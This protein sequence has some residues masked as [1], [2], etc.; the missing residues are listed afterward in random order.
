MKKNYLST[1]NIFLIFLI[2]AILIPL[3]Y[4]FQGITDQ[5]LF[6]HMGYTQFFLNS[7]HFP[8]YWDVY[9]PK[10]IPGTVS[11]Y[12]IICK[13][14]NIVPETLQFIPLVGIILPVVYYSLC[15]KFTDDPILPIVFT[16][17]MILTVPPSNFLTVWTH[18]WGYLLLIVF[19]FLYFKLYDKKDSCI[20]YLLIL[21]FTSIHFFSYTTEM[22]SI[23][24]SA[25]INLILFISLYVFRNKINK[26][27]LSMNLSLIFFIICF[28][29]NQIIYQAFLRKGEYINSISRSCNI[30]YGISFLHQKTASL[31]EYSYIPKSYPLIT[32]FG[33]SYYALISFIIF[34]PLIFIFINFIKNK[35]IKIFNE[36]S[37][38]SLFKYSI[39]I[40]VIADFII[41]SMAGLFTTRTILFLFPIAALISIEELKLKIKYKYI[42]TFILFLLALVHSLS[43]IYYEVYQV[44]YSHY[45]Y[46]EPSS[47]W[48]LKNADN[49]DALTDLRTGNKYF[50]Q[51]ASQNIICTKHVI[52]YEQYES[53]VN[54]HVDGSA[55]SSLRKV[56]PYV[57]LNNK[58]MSI[59]SDSWEEYKPYSLYAFKINENS[60]INKI[61]SDNT[62]LIFKT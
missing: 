6:E 14:T 2:I 12:L 33:V 35:N 52:N 54:P 46:I 24:F 3:L 50:L 28:M 30:F 1:L 22:W 41:Y 13:V 57:I 44:D 60:K 9:S 47:N 48:F 29:F 58:L 39:L 17:C 36:P 7:S 53:I 21:V 15:K 40:V 38:S 4:S 16:L 18:A 42:F 27:K 19:A 34:I 56:S 49:K 61:Y 8:I 43:G 45:N 11:L 62:I 37:K 10:N 55:E 23:T 31:G 25:A 32:F 51:G 26:N 20:T 59:Q 5:F